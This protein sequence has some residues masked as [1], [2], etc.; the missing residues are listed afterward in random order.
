M[1]NG[2]FSFASTG[3]FA[4]THYTNGL[5]SVLL[6]LGLCPVRWQ[7]RQGKG[8]GQLLVQPLPL[9]TVFGFN[10]FDIFDALQHLP[11]LGTHDSLFL[12]QLFSPLHIQ[13]LSV[14]L[15]GAL[16]DHFVSPGLLQHQVLAPHFI[17]LLLRHAVV[18]PQSFLALFFLKASYCAVA[19]R[20]SILS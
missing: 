5:H 9:S 20:R 10:P 15:V 12:G 8:T 11:P 13:A 1:F 18:A 14:C 2:L 16:P 7:L 6:R 3:P 19:L 4:L 17:S